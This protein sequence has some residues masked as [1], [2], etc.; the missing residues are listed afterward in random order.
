M[1][2]VAASGGSASQAGSVET[3]GA[4]SEFD[5]QFV[6]AKNRVGKQAPDGVQPDRIELVQYRIHMDEYQLFYIRF[7]CDRCHRRSPAVA[8]FF[9]VFGFAVL[10]IAFVNEKINVGNFCNILGVFS[11]HRVGDIGKGSI[12]PVQAVTQRSPRMFQRKAGN[13]ACVAQ[14]KRRFQ[15][16]EGDG[17]HGGEKV[18]GEQVFLDGV[19]FFRIAICGDARNVRLVQKVEQERQSDHMVEVSVRQ[20]NIEVFGFDPGACPKQGR[21]GV[22]QNAFGGEHHAGGMA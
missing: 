8:G 11:S 19:E 14:D 17:G 9:G 12:G 18:F 3:P 2:V 6:S 15:W 20:E 5:F 21:T 7:F 4:G 13:T 16:R 22:E 1:G 10:E